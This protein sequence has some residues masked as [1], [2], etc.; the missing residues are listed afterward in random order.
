M[1]EGPAGVALPIA[2]HLA[3]AEAARMLDLGDWPREVET[4]S[5]LRHGAAVN[6]FLSRHV[7]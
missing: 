1:S 7:S 6:S 5:E 3:Q 4:G 2:D